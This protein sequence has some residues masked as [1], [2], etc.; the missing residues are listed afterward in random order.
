MAPDPLRAAGH[1]RRALAK[2]SHGRHLSI[3]LDDA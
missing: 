3:A 2:I 1:D